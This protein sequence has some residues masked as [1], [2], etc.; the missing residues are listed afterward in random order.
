MIRKAF[1]LLPDVRGCLTEGY[2]RLGVPADYHLPR[3]GFSRVAIALH[4]LYGNLLE[5]IS[6]DE[7][8]IAGISQRPYANE[9]PVAAVISSLLVEDDSPKEGTAILW[10]QV[11]CKPLLRQRNIALIAAVVQQTAALGMSLGHF[12]HTRLRNSAELARFRAYRLCLDAT[13][14][15][16]E[17]RSQKLES[18][19]KSIEQSTGLLGDLSPRKVPLFWSNWLHT[20]IKRRPPWSLL[21]WLLRL[22]HLSSSEVQRHWRRTGRE[23]KARDPEDQT[24]LSELAKPEIVEIRRLYGRDS[25]CGALRL[26]SLCFP[27]LCTSPLGL[28][29][30]VVIDILRKCTVEEGPGA[31]YVA[32]SCVAL[33]GQASLRT[34]KFHGSIESGLVSTRVYAP[35]KRRKFVQELVRPSSNLFFRY[36]PATLCQKFQHHLHRL[37]RKLL[38]KHAQAW[39]NANWGVHRPTVRKLERALVTNGPLWFGYDW[40]YGYYAME[41]G[42]RKGHAAK[43]YCQVSQLSGNAPKPICGLSLTFSCRP[44]Q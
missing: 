20:E 42:R 25:Y 18:A 4:L 21:S 14:C 13:E 19:R 38:L 41:G 43:S 33:A 15:W 7:Q 31:C 32:F 6:F 39:L 22:D 16:G 34:L 29:E 8:L 11:R 37:G 3:R 40:I 27:S 2:R 26:A 30:S 12:G 23:E 28:P 1:D 24:S 44:T 10:E 5:G 36:L 17:T 35:Q 9:D